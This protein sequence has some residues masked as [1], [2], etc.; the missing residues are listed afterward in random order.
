[1]AKRVSLREFQEGLVRRLADAQSAPRRDLLGLAA[2]SAHWLLDLS[3]AGEILPVPALATVPLT[4]H[5]FRGLANVRG[6]LFGIVDLSAFCGGPLISPGG[7]ARLVLIGQRHGANCGLLVSATTGL[8]SPDDF[9]LDA[10]TPPEHAW[11]SRTLRDTHG[12]PWQHIDA[13]RLLGHPAFLEAS[14]A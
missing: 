13:P 8:R 3:D 6:T 12:R 9:D 4:R 2:G 11:V 10:D 14:A 5:W 7:A 1:M